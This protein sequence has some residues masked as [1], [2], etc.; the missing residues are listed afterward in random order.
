MRTERESRRLARLGR[1]SLLARG[2]RLQGAG[3]RLRALLA[4]WS[5][6]GEAGLAAAAGE[7]RLGARALKREGIGEKE[8]EK[9][10]ER[11]K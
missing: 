1:S 9:R 6:A 5:G 2:T 4:P 3:A 10:G 11:E 7:E 8:R